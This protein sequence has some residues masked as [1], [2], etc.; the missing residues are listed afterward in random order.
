MPLIYKNNYLADMLSSSIQSPGTYED[1]TNFTI[2]DIIINH[3]RK[4]SLTTC[5]FISEDTNIPKVAFVLTQDMELIEYLKMKKPNLEKTLDILEPSKQND[6]VSITLGKLL[7][8]LETNQ[9]DYE[10]EIDSR[11]YSFRLVRGVKAKNLLEKID[12]YIE[13]K[14]NIKDYAVEANKTLKF[15]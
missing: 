11:K 9:G 4:N 6:F 14:E 7:N 12:T 2:E 5:F 1:F 13:E 10:L 8:N 3:H 15:N